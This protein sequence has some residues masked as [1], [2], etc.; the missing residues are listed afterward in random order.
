MYSISKKISIK[1]Q[2]AVSKDVFSNAEI[3]QFAA[4]KFECCSCGH[5]NT[6]KITPYESGFPIFQLYNDEKVLTKNE[7]LSN[8]IVSETSINLIHFGELTVNDLPTLYFGTDCATCGSKYICIFSYG[9]KQPGLTL[10]TISG[11]WK[12]NEI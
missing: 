2:V 3:G 4:V 8:K 7:L 6:V 5:E 1:K 9:E 12:Y 10:L 11:V